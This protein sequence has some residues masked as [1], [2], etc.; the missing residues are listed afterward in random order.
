MKQELGHEVTAES[1]AGVKGLYGKNGAP[2]VRTFHY[3]ND[4]VWLHRD[5]GKWNNKMQ[6]LKCSINYKELGT[7]SRET[8]PG[9]EFLKSSN[10]DYGPGLGQIFFFKSRIKSKVTKTKGPRKKNWKIR[11]QNP[12]KTRLCAHRHRAWRVRLQGEYFQFETMES[13]LKTLFTPRSKGQGETWKGAQSK[14]GVQSG[15]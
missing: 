6:I 11:L 14:S 8:G 1:S 13:G 5:Q 7:C 10:W 3:L 12:K 2:W 4:L 15:N 9:E